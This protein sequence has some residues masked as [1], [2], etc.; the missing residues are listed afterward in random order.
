M[1]SADKIKENVRTGS[2]LCSPTFSHSLCWKFTAL[3]RRLT[4][5]LVIK[6]RPELLMIWSCQNSCNPKPHG[7][8]KSLRA[9]WRQYASLK[10][11][12][13]SVITKGLYGWVIRE[14][15]SCVSHCATRHILDTS[16]AHT[17]MWQFNIGGNNLMLLTEETDF[18]VILEDSALIDAFGWYFRVYKWG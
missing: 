4:C 14:M 17:H 6:N 13:K 2:E 12:G 11:L 1:W 18:L 5:Y 10:L 8:S 7:W 15:I 16:H 3:A 9:R